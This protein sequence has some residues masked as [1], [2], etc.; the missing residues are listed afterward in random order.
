MMDR[1]MV[2]WTDCSHSGGK[3]HGVSTANMAKGGPCHEEHGAWCT[4]TLE[5]HSPP[6]LHKPSFI[7]KIGQFTFVLL[8][9]NCG[10]FRK[11]L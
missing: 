1:I 4:M 10:H 8:K 7:S 3:R 9:V 5:S 11:G 2:A 6:R